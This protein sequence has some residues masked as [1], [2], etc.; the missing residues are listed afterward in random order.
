MKTN[1]AT[2]SCQ[3]NDHHPDPWQ[4]VASFLRISR[5]KHA[6]PCL[7][8]CHASWAEHG[9]SEKQ[10]ENRTRRWIN[11]IHSWILKA[12]VNQ[13]SAGCPKLFSASQQ[14][15]RRGEDN[16]SQRETQHGGRH[17]SLFHITPRNDSDRSRN[18]RPHVDHLIICLIVSRSEVGDKI[19]QRSGI[20][21]PEA[22]FWAV[23]KAK[24]TG[25]QRIKG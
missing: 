10:D 5:M 25:N 4:S 18:L 1:R 20:T 19:V 21:F 16:Q 6:S 24:N 13:L 7:C 8:L 23:N 17:V 9:Q 12:T 22:I 11:S 3:L 14:C 2:P 15:H